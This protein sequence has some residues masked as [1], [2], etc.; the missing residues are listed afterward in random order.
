MITPKE[1]QSIDNK[2]VIRKNNYT[3]RPLLFS[4]ERP[5]PKG[6]QV[7]YIHGA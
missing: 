1:I 3:L 5:A 6:N 2:L 4:P 7:K